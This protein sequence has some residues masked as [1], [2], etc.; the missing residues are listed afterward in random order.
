[1]EPLPPP[2]QP[3]SAF[4]RG[5]SPYAPPGTLPSAAPYRQGG[6]PGQPA[7]PGAHV[8]LYKPGQVALATFLGTPMGGAVLYAM[9]ERRLGRSDGARNAIIFG[10]AA[11]AILF[12]IAFALPNGFPSAPIGIVPVVL[13]QHIARTKQGVLVSQHG[14]AGGK[15][16]SSWAAAG[17]G[18]AT[19]FAVLIPVF[20]VAFVV[21]MLSS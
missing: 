6:D 20:V 16:G 10:L 19:C 15:I 12:G 4:D 8:T 13:M 18:V 17:I 9:N 1:M 11:T 21:A 5:F 14:N 3:S 2:T 7:L